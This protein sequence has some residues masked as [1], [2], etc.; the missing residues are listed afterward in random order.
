MGGAIERLW[1]TGGGERMLY[2][3]FALQSQRE[4]MVGKMGILRQKRAVHVCTV[5]ITIHGPF[6][7]ILCIIA[8]SFQHPAQRFGRTQVGAPA[9]VLEANQRA[10][11]PTDRHIS[12]A[13]GNM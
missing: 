9:V 11:I 2:A 3:I 8:V 5:G 4:Q 7:V 6:A 13:T 12:D 1:L 10:S